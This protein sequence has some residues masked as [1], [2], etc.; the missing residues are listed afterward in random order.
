MH[1]DFSGAAASPSGDSTLAAW[2]GGKWEPGRGKN[3]GFS[4]AESEQRKEPE[5]SFVE[6]GRVSPDTA[7]GFL[8][9]TA[10]AI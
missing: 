5:L 10:E 8:G 2:I 7:F 9:H 3:S 1:S 4:G 6:F